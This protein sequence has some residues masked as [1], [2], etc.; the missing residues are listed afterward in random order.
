MYISNYMQH[1]C[2][3]QFLNDYINNNKLVC[4][5]FILFHRCARSV[6][7]SD[8]RRAENNIDWLEKPIQLCYNNSVHPT[9]IYSPHKTI[10]YFVQSFMEPYTETLGWNMWT[11]SCIFNFWG[12]VEIWKKSYH[13]FKHKG[14]FKSSSS[15]M[16]SF[17]SLVSSTAA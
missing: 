13:I 3:L 11:F 9:V 7:L 14:L 8:H 5:I 6:Y 10:L 15:S 17:F 16:H 2:L 1:K 12:H 4:V